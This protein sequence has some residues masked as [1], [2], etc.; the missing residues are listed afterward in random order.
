M[1]PDAQLAKSKDKRRRG[2]GVLEEALEVA[3]G[4][5]EMLP[6]MV[7]TLAYLKAAPPT[8]LCPPTS[9]VMDCCA[10]TSVD[11]FHAKESELSTVPATTATA[12]SSDGDERHEH[13]DGHVYVRYAAEKPQARPAEG[14]VAHHQHRR[15]TP[16]ARRPSANMTMPR[17]RRG[18]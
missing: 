16:Q 14:G 17:P 18:T 13:Q 9:S 12:R 5:E 15:R 11:I 10:V 7:Y 3:R 2:G 8:A 1:V 6:S 4:A